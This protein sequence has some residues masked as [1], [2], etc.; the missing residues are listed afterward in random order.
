MVTVL[1]DYNLGLCA[2]VTVCYQL[3]FFFVAF[4]CKFDKV[5]DFAGGTNFLVL[6]IVTLVMAGTFAPRQIV[7][8]V[9]VA[10]WGLRIA[11]FLLYR[12]LKSGKDEVRL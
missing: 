6:A 3:S 9:L 2:I 8:T 7:V 4:G 11:C 5:T 12:I 1:D 10:L